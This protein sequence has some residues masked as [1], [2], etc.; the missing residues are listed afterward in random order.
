MQHTADNVDH[1]SRTLDGQNTF[2]GMGIVATVTPKITVTRTVPKVKV[3]SEEIKE[4]GRIEIH[5]PQKK[6]KPSLKYEKLKP[7]EVAKN[8]LT[9]LWNAAWLLEPQRAL[10]NGF[11]QS[12]HK[13]AVYPGQSSVIFL[14][15][16]DLK[17]SDEVCILSTMAFVAKQADRLNIRPILTFDQPLY[18]KAVELQVNESESSLIRKIILRLGGLHTCMSFLGSIGHLMNSS[19]LQQALET[20][21]AENTVP[22]ML[23]GKALSRA[24]RGHMI[25]SGVLHAIMISQIYDSPISYTEEDI[26]G[27]EIDRSEQEIDH[28]EHRLLEFAKG[29]KLEEI[30]QLFE[31]LMAGKISIE[32][33]NSDSTLIDLKNLIDNFKDKR[34]KSR[35]ANLWLQY[36]EMVEILLTFIKGERTGDFNLHL[37]A[38]SKM[39]PYFASSG[40][41]HYAKSAHIY[42]QTMQA[43]EKESPDVYTK[44]QNGYHVVRRSDRYW[45][46]LSTD[47]IIEQVTDINF[48]LN[49]NLWS[50]LQY[51]IGISAFGSLRKLSSA[52]TSFSTSMFFLHL[53]F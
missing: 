53:R 5:F 52:A 38:L 41:H 25:T 20:A 1:N 30:S 4:K 17:S 22:H 29:S 3:T 40:H 43:L 24:I 16:I 31:L 9:L 2:H 11:M 51:K 49:R 34:K 32:E 36:M 28:S 48:L 39:L 26:D 44:F 19:G 13:T 21:Y 46:G 42:L 27:E 6:S 47:L 18:Q 45:A 50:N 37:N 35:T 8:S 14:L 15:M 7:V 23:T 12:T 10:W 33:V